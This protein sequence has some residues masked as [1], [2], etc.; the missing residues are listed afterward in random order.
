MNDYKDF[1]LERQ[2]PLRRH[3]R[4]T[5]EDAWITDRGRTTGGTGLDPFHGTVIAGE[6]ELQWDIGIHRAVGGFHDRAN[7]GDMLCAALAACF[8]TSL[9]IIAAR[10][11]LKVERLHVGVTGEIDVRGTLAVDPEVPVGMQRIDCEVDLALAPGAPDGATERLISAAER[12]CVVLQTLRHGVPI[13]LHMTESAIA[14]ARPI[15]ARGEERSH[16]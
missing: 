14:E 4:E 3:Y 16:V 13:D 12:A 2:E 11:G 5:P 1:V 9:R 15:A 6:G 10:Y 8:D 7:P